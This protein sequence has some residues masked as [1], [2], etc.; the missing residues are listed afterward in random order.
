M[1]TLCF[2]PTFL[3]AIPSQAPPETTLTR[4]LQLQELEDE[5][6]ER[7]QRQVKREK[8]CSRSQKQMLRR[9]V[10]GGSI[11]DGDEDMINQDPSSGEEGNP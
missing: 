11:E 4:H 8:R 2:A 5:G 10:S 7:R 6:K 3:P 1:A 9:R